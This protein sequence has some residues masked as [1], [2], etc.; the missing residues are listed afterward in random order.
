MKSP[1]SSE[2]EY[3]HYIVTLPDGGLMLA[4]YSEGI[5]GVVRTFSKGKAQR[6]LKDPER[7][8]RVW[9]QLES[10][11]HKDYVPRIT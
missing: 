1:M 7:Q 11:A 6:F 8:K 10:D 2:N 9:K 3:K 5:P 4:V